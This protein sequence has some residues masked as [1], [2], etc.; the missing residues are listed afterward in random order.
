MCVSGGGGGG[1]AR[2]CSRCVCAYVARCVC[3][4]VYRCT[5]TR[6][7]LGKRKKNGE[8]E[9]ESFVGVLKQVLNCGRVSILVLKTLQ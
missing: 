8:S 9:T 1:G 4:C 6:R 3:V 7:V 5:C 2:V